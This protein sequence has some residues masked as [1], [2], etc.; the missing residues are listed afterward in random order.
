[1][2]AAVSIAGGGSVGYPKVSVSGVNGFNGTVSLSASGLPAGATASFS[3][4]SITAA[5]VSLLTITT[6]SSTPAGSYPLT[7]TGTSGSLTHT[8]PLTLTVTSTATTL[9]SGWTSQDIGPGG[10]GTGSSYS[11][12]TYTVSGTGCCLWN[13]TDSFQFAYQTLTGDGTIIA[14]IASTT[15]FAFGWTTMAGVMIRE[16][17]DPGSAYSFMGLEA[18]G[19]GADF[20][21]RTT[22]FASTGNGT[23]P[24]VSAPYWVKLV[25]SVNSF[26]GYVSADGNTWTQVGG[27]YTVPMAGTV[28]VGLAVTSGTNGQVTTATFDN[29]RVTQ[30]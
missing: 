23:G 18:G 19:Y 21:A 22:T 20:Q 3:P 16:T 26:T 30:P 4:V 6:T 28:Y 12:G 9:P 7:I 1:V 15:N 27:T 14:R 24:A 25:R 17:L 13:S 11:S 10:T 2:P 5:G 8:F 29:W